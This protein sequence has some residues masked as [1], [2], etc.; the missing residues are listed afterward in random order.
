[1]Q[2][3]V[4]CVFLICICLL[5]EQTKAIKHKQCPRIPRPR[6]ESVWISSNKNSCPR[7]TQKREEGALVG[8]K[9]I[10]QCL[11]TSSCRNGSAKELRIKKA[12]SESWLIF[13]LWIWPPVRETSRLSLLRSGFVMRL[14]CAFICIHGIIYIERRT[15]QH[16]ST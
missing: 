1:M 6:S 7:P 4:R 10:S 13:Q 16:T 3:L 5:C 2:P 12:T 9:M 14:A 8:G 15:Q 11:F